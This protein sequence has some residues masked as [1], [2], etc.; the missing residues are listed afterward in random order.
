LNRLGLFALAALIPLFLAVFGLYRAA[1]LGFDS[2]GMDFLVYWDAVHRWAA[3]GPVYLPWQLAGPYEIHGSGAELAVLMPP[4]FLLLAAPFAVLPREAA[5]ALWV[6]VPPAVIG[7]AILRLRP[8]PWSWPVLGLLVAW[9]TTGI[10]VA[11][12]NPTV[13][14]TAVLALSLATRHRWLAAMVLVKPSL[15][16]F[17]FAGVRSRGWW[18]LVAVGFVASLALL[19]LFP[20][21]LRAIANSDAGLLYSLAH[22]PTMAIPVVAWA[23]RP[24]ARSGSVAG[25]PGRCGT[26]GPGVV[27]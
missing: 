10:L 20:D 13:A 5:G 25:G 15:A 24:P 7:W 19:P 17:A 2:W 27:P 1:S 23:A 21:W 16:P 4:P 18:I 14:L 12:G 26:I 3:G 22:F 6:V 11:T 9:P 8:R